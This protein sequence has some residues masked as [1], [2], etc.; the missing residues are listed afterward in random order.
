MAIL[1][2]V[3]MI[4]RFK[5][6]PV[7]ALVG[8]ARLGFVVGLG[9]DGAITAVAESVSRREPGDFDAV[10]PSRTPDIV[11]PC[12]PGPGDRTIELR[13]G[14]RRQRRQTLAR[15]FHCDSLAGSCRA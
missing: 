1:A 11:P 12:K 10:T 3:M 7:V 14:L 2:V 8:F 13:H 15:C 9:L 6:N 5:F 4:V